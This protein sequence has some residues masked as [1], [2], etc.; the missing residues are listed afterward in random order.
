[1]SELIAT[2]IVKNKF[3][4]VEDQG[5]KIATIQARDDGGYVYVH[6]DSREYFPNVKSLKNTYH[7]KFNAALKRK[8]LN[9]T[10]VYGYPVNGK[11]YNQIWDVKRK[12]PIF[13]KTKKSKSYFCAGY[14]MVKINHT[15]TEF[16]CPKNITLNRYEFLGPFKTKEDLN[17]LS[18]TNY[19]KS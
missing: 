6:D 7:I 9:I 11:S 14:Y 18:K 3:W 4:V 19:E 13:T 17:L 15:W 10:N 8:N 12:L 1:M 5:E 2:P 16:F